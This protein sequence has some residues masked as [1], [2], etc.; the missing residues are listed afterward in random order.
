MVCIYM[1]S[2]KYNLF[3]WIH[4]IYYIIIIIKV[5]FIWTANNCMYYKECGLSF[6]CSIS[7]TMANLSKQNMPLLSSVSCA[8]LYGP[9]TYSCLVII[10]IIFIFVVLFYLFGKLKDNNKNYFEWIIYWNIKINS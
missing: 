4:F 10:I 2:Y 9:G 8:A 5:S 6:N 1:Y 7:T 3:N